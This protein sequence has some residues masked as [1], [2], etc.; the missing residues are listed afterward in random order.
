MQCGRV[1]MGGLCTSG[2]IALLDV[3]LAASANC[4]LLMHDP[5]LCMAGSPILWLTPA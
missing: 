1:K 5:V 4:L 3:R 2:R